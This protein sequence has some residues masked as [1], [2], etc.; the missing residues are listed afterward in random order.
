MRDARASAAKTVI[1]RILSSTLLV[2][3]ALTLALGLGLGSAYWAVGGR[4]SVWKHQ[5]GTLDRMVAHRLP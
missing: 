4:L 2:L 5:G 1:R 3:Y